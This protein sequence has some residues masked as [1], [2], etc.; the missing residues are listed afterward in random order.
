MNWR[1]G[2]WTPGEDNLLLQIINR[3]GAENW[4]KISEEMHGRSPKQC[5]ERYHQNLKPSL[6]HQPITEDEGRLINHLVETLGRRWAEIA[7][8]LP[9]RSDN[10]VKNWWNGGANR[11]KRGH[12]R[13]NHREAERS[14]SVGHAPSG[15]LSLPQSSSAQPY[16]PFAVQPVGG[17]T[18][19]PYSNQSRQLPLPQDG[20]SRQS[21]GGDAF[22]P[23]PP[24]PNFGRRHTERS[25]PS[26]LEIQNPATYQQ[27]HHNYHSQQY[28]QPLQSPSGLSAVSHDTPSLV[29]DQSPIPSP[30]TPNPPPSHVG[31]Y[32]S[33]SCEENV[34]RPSPMEPRVSQHD[35]PRN[36]S[37]IAYHVEI[38]N[39]LPP[40]QQMV[41]ERPMEQH[42]YPPRLS[43]TEPRRQDSYSY[44]T[45]PTTVES[46]KRSSMMDIK[47]ITQ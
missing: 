5:R 46:P 16:Q 39:K 1:R 28:A 18:Y 30:A 23:P 6:N 36:D 4:V 14:R 19:P 2:P 11:R 41:P 33:R 17:Y 3:T 47:A 43:H 37:V 25:L 20:S 38:A 31:H 29:T 10:A 26:P 15:M 7:R 13:I 12:D 40:I 9:G 45:S 44:P 21:A 22:G 24:P 27:Y 34:F 35:T 42:N 32:P 8:R